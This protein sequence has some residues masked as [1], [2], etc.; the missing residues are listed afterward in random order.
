MG[1]PLK[2]DGDEREDAAAAIAAAIAAI[3]T[4]GELAL[5][6]VLT[7]AV[8]K[9]LPLGTVTMAGLAQLRQRVAVVLPKLGDL[10]KR[11]AG[12]GAPGYGSL[13]SRAGGAARS[14]A[15]GGPTSTWTVVPRRSRSS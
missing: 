1:D 11:R 4:A 6:Q 9:A 7:S 3:Y 13:A 14:R 10:L 8:R 12:V 2:V 15:C 5:L